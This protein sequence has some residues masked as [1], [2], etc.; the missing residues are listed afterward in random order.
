MSNCLVRRRLTWSKW[1]LKNHC[2][3]LLFTKEVFGILKINKCLLQS[4]TYA[5][6]IGGCKNV[7]YLRHLL[8][9]ELHLESLNTQIKN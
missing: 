9:T 3:S 2:V 1:F 6:K 7:L 8:Q 5:L 4:L